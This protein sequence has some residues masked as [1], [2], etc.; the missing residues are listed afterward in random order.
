MKLLLPFTLLIAGA[1]LMQADIVQTISFDL[2]ALHAGSTLS[3]TF[4]LS[5]TPMIGD[6]SS[7]SLS[8]S[9]PADYTPTSLT[10]TI[11]IQGSTP[12]GG[13]AI[14]FSS[15]AFTNL[16]GV[17]TP[18]NTRDVLLNRTLHAQCASFPCTATGLFEDRNP[19]VFTA[20]YTIAPGA[21]AVIPEPGY[22]LLVAVLLIGLGFGYRRVRTPQREHAR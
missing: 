13:F 5:N 2:S 8:F 4:A 6:T 20:Q 22:S 1:G 7:A 21:A 9:D 19:P 15:L 12:P 18:I 14:D 17:T 3:G 10:T 16:S 11:T